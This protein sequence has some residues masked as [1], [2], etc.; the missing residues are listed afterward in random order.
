MMAFC[1]IDAM[2]SPLSI[3]F[4]AVSIPHLQSLP[5]RQLPAGHGY[6]FLENPDSRFDTLLFAAKTM[7]RYQANEKPNIELN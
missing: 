7:R 3:G 4:A 1:L 2:R 5:L 6:S